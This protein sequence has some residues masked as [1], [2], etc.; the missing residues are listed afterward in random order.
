M[1]CSLVSGMNAD[2][3]TGNDTVEARNNEIL[4][5]L[6]FRTI[7]EREHTLD[8]AYNNTCAWVWSHENLLLD[9]KR[10]KPYDFTS[11]LQ[12]FEPILWIS[13]KAGC[14]KSTLMKYIHH[15]PRTKAL[16][17]ASPWANGKDLIILRYFFYE[18]GSDLQKSREGMLR[19][20]LI[21][22]L[23]E[24]RHLIP[25]VFP[26]LFGD[27]NKSS[28][29]Q[30]P[31]DTLMNSFGWTN[32][33]AAFISVLEHL[34]DSRLL[35]FLDGLDEYRM[36]GRDNQYTEEELD[37]IYDGNNEDDAWGRSTW[38]TDGHRE[39]AQFIH[40]LTTGGNAKVCISSRELNLFEHTFRHSLRIRVHDHTSESIKQYCENRLTQ[41]APEL[42][43]LPEFISDISGQSCGVFLW[44]RLIVDML[45]EEHVNGGHTNELQEI[46]NKLPSR[47]GGKNGLYMH[48]MRNIERR[49]LPES[50]RLF[51]LAAR[52]HDFNIHDLD[53]I[54]LFLAEEGYLLEENSEV[55]RASNDKFEPK[56]WSEWET[57]MKN[58]SKR[59]KGRC[60]LLLEGTDKVRFMHQTVQQF[61]TRKYLWAEIFGNATGFRSEI[62]VD[63]ALLSGLIRRL[64]C[65]AEAVVCSGEDMENTRFQQA[66]DAADADPY[67]EVKNSS[68]TVELFNCIVAA[69]RFCHKP[70]LDQSVNHERHFMK[71]LDELD[72]IGRHHTEK[73]RAPR[74]IPDTSWP[75]AYIVLEAYDT[76]LGFAMNNSLD[77][78]IIT[79]IYPLVGNP[80][81][82]HNYSKDELSLILLKCA[83]YWDWSF[84][85]DP[86]CYSWAVST[87]LWFIESVLHEGADPNLRTG[88]PCSDTSA[89][90][91]LTPWTC[92]LDQFFTREKYTHWLIDPFIETA[93][94]FLEH[95][96]DPTVQWHRTD[97]RGVDTV[98]SALEGCIE[99]LKAEACIDEFSINH[100][101][102]LSEILRQ[103]EEKRTRQLADSGTEMD[104]D[105]STGN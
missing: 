48:M 58:L 100:L 44:V 68:R 63:L 104:S 67:F 83:R 50:R 1:L 6:S 72:V 28:L 17:E 95:G 47:L 54:A 65:C 79:G 93:K 102:E 46:V 49:Y 69:G 80:I 4:D 11:W 21:Q 82:G 70:G 27:A 2:T 40:S 15:D 3:L 62:D 45:V 12:S 31:P 86:V 26:R 39:I 16:S 56:T 81:E 41:E 73:F 43:G 10:A 22:V 71:L 5:A 25:M 19:T 13:G 38:I 59:L 52:C 23:N 97:G 29:H 75:G 7:H 37:L 101:E 14:G 74:N 76:R 94:V 78:T 20:M 36:A 24:R 96:A 85:Q 66:S 9:E 32:L 98:G 55:M 42:T 91:S 34:K 61:I 92:L 30:F 87:P 99:R 18:L 33:R 8:E 77:F 57:R 88:V 89:K 35:I 60:G 51:Q 53:I 64:K 84:R 105:L 103:T 90:A